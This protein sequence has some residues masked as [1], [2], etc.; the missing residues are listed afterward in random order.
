MGRGQGHRL[1]GKKLTIGYQERFAQVGQVLTQLRDMEA[2]L[3]AVTLVAIGDMAPHWDPV[4]RDRQPKEQLLEV[5]PVVAT[6]AIR[7]ARPLVV[8]PLIR[9][10]ELQTGSLGM[11]ARQVQG[12]ALDGLADHRPIEAVQADAPQRIQCSAQATV[13]EM[14]RVH[15]TLEDDLQVVACQHLCNTGEG[16]LAGENGQ[17]Q[18][19]DALPHGDLMTLVGWDEGIERLFH[20]QLPQHGA[21]EGQVVQAFDVNNLRGQW[22]EGLH[23]FLLAIVP[24]INLAQRGQEDST[25]SPTP[26]TKIQRLRHPTLEC[27]VQSR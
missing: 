16:V 7:H 23:P 12:I 21:Y 17:H 10:V 11:Q 6:I 22:C 15:R 24:S 13:M 2:M 9:P 20:G 5:R 4:S 27:R 8:A 14:C 18:A 19:L 26:R 3:R 1:P 25:H